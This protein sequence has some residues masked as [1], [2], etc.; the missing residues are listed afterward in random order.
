MIPGFEVTVPTVFMCFDERACRS[1]HDSLALAGKI[2]CFYARKLEIDGCTVSIFRLE[3][4]KHT[5]G[6]ST[7]LFQ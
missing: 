2:F 5:I 7:L 4:S 1:N 3:C 6:A